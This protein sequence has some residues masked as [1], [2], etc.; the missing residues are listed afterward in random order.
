MHE[1]WPTTL[2]DAIVVGA[3]PAGSTVA[4]QLARAGWSV[5]LIERQR[6]PRKV[7]GECIAASNL[8][9]LAALDGGYR[10]M[11]VA[12][13]RVVTIACCPR[14]D[15]LS[16]LRGGVAQRVRTPPASG[17]CLRARR[18]AA[19]RRGGADEAGATLAGTADAGR[20]LG[21]EGPTRRAGAR[22]LS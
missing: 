5:T 14:R 3:G 15:R 11:V 4:I 2:F 19:P 18:H 20:A 8:P 21:R 1:A 13:D 22:A 6:F 16:K 7:C 10:G 12:D 9:L 17:G